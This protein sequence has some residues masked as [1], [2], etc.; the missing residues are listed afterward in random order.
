MVVE[1]LVY[2]TIIWYYMYLRYLSV[3]RGNMVPAKS[4]GLFGDVC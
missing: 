2:G 3:V 4:A 1:V